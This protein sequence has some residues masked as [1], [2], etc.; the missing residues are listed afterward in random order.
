M[1]TLSWQTLLGRNRV[2][3]TRYRDG[4]R[5]AGLPVSSRAMRLTAEVLEPRCLLTDAAGVEFTRSG[6]TVVIPASQWSDD[7]LTLVVS[8]D[9]FEIGPTGESAMTVIPFESVSRLVLQGRNQAADELSV[10]FQ[11][12]PAE[13]VPKIEFDGGTGSQPD[14]LRFVYWNIECQIE[15]KPN[16]SGLISLVESVD[17]IELGV[18]AWRLS[19]RDVEWVRDQ[20]QSDH[21]VVQ[22]GSENNVVTL[23]PKDEFGFSQLIDLTTDA[24]IESEWWS[25][26]NGGAGNDR[27]TAI[28]VLM[29]SIC[30]QSGNDTL[31]ASDY[32][33]EL[34]G[35]TGNDLLRGGDDADTLFGDAGNDTLEGSAGDDQVFGSDGD[36][37][38]RGGDDAD[39]LAGELGNDSLEGDAGSDSLYGGYANEDLYLFYRNSSDDPAS[40]IDNA[41]RDTIRGGSGDDQVYGDAGNDSLFGESGVDFLSGGLGSDKLD[42]GDDD[43]WLDGDEG[44]D[45]LFGSD[46]SDRLDEMYGSNLLDGGAG[47]DRLEIGQDDEMP[48]L[49]NTLLGQTGNDHLSGGIGNDLLAGGDGRD[50]LDDAFGNDTMRGDE[51]N[52]WIT[53]SDGNDLLDGGS[54]R[55]TVFGEM[56]DDT[57]L[58]SAGNDFL[59]GG[60]GNDSV[61]GG[62]E[63]DTLIGDLGNDT[64]L[65][66]DGN[67]SL[68]GSD[69]NNLLDGGAGH[70][71]LTG[72]FDRDKLYGGEGND[73]LS[74]LDGAD[75]LD[76]GPGRDKLEGNWYFGEDEPGDQLLNG[77]LTA[78]ESWD[79]EYSDIDLDAEATTETIIT[80]ADWTDGGLTVFWEYGQIC[81]K[82]TDTGEYLINT[83]SPGDVERWVIEGRAQADD[84]LTVDL[85]EWSS[86]YRF[87]AIQFDGGGN[88]DELRL[89][90]GGWFSI[91]P[92]P[93]R[94]G[95]IQA[96][97]DKAYD[98]PTVSYKNVELVRDM[99]GANIV[100]QFQ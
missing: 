66:R 29:E 79:D 74:G 39:I 98:Q 11:A 75:R 80:A 53:G 10:Q 30:G 26:V 22:F 94:S 3:G 16:R 44:N 83:N 34:Y 95:W 60:E 6:S 96:A 12:S 99:A 20:S 23:S 67:D 87:P 40:R 58:G 92:R 7:G 5:Q 37:V 68:D 13:R 24:V 1:R 73:Y 38:L 48:A 2:R 65:G 35:G 46:G 32:G 49:S 59:E 85:S 76:G 64:L 62:S 8:H 41:G 86:R 18:G 90:S 82:R 14:R 88:A 43:D 70:D 31:I 69:G 97:G 52:D 57:L 42:G 84:V 78:D 45:S 47:D 81:V 54:G 27:I 9:A 17:A 77:E 100:F 28:D 72:G 63:R 19:Y 93:N 55:D 4:R 51:G 50:T 91:A 15:P 25:E 61:D 36:D 71:R 89:V 21:R 33:A 56:G